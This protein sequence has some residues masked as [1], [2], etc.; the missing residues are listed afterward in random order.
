VTAPTSTPPVD[1]ASKLRRIMGIGGE[2]P[3]EDE[4]LLCVRAVYRHMLQP[5]T[6]AVAEAAVKALYRLGEL[7]GEK[8]TQITEAL[9]QEYAERNKGE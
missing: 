8:H 9:N 3:R 5:R 7:A 6:F 1:Q 4:A 2:R